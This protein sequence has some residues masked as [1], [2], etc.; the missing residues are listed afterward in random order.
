[1][2]VIEGDLEH[3]RELTDLGSSIDTKGVST[4]CFSDHS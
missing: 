4:F 2:C 1:M 3:L